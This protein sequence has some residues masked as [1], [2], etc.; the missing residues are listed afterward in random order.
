[1]RSLIAT[2]LTLCALT[3]PAEAQ[4]FF[5]DFFHYEQPRIP[6]TRDCAGA[7]WYGEFSGNRHD[8]FRDTYN[9]VAARGCFR[10][11]RRPYD[12]RRDVR[13]RNR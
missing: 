13:H 2:V 7:A 3:A 12:S 6:P 5:D 1:M 8:D 10:E 9:P 11:G 4:Y